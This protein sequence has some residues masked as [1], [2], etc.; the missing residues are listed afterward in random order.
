MYDQHITLLMHCLVTQVHEDF[1]V[2][3]QAS[4]GNSGGLRLLYVLCGLL[5][6]GCGPTPV[7]ES[8]KEFHHSRD[9]PRRSVYLPVSGGH[10]QVVQGKVS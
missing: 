1:P 6:T 7:H 9:V 2:E 8:K 4:G 10:H 3:G 5:E